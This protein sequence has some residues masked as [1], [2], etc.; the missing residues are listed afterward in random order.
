MNTLETKIESILADQQETI[1]EQTTEL[2]KMAKRLQEELGEMIRVTNEIID[3]KAAN[4]IHFPVKVHKTNEWEKLPEALVELDI[5]IKARHHLKV[6]TR[7][8]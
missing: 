2:K 8:I 3:D 1:I 4:S 7:I 6:K 5:R